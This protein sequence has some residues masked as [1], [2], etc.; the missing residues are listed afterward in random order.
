MR[1]TMKLAYL[2]MTCLALAGLSSVPAEAQMVTGVRLTVG[3]LAY[4][5]TSINATVAV[6]ARIPNQYLGPKT[7]TASIYE[8]DALW[9]GD[10]LV[11]TGTFVLT[12]A[13]NANRIE[14][15]TSTI[16]LNCMAC[17]GGKCD[18]GNVGMIDDEHGVHEVYASVGGVDSKIWKVACAKTTGGVF[19]VASGITPPGGSS[20]V[21]VSLRQE[22]PVAGISYALQYDPTWLSVTEASFDPAVVAAFQLTNVDYSV[23]GEVFFEAITEAP[24][25]VMLEEAFDLN[26]TFAVDALAPEGEYP[27]SSSVSSTVLD[28]ELQ[29]VQVNLGDE[30]FVVGAE[31]TDAPVIDASLVHYD[32]AAGTVTGAAGAVTEALARGVTRSGTG[33]IARIDA[34]LLDTASGRNTAGEVLA[35]ANGGFFV[36]GLVQEGAEALAIVATDNIGNKSASVEA[37]AVPQNPWR[38]STGLAGRQ[39]NADSSQPSLTHDGSYVV[40]DSNATN[41]VRNDTNGHKDVFVVDRTTGWTVRASV[42]SDGEQANGPSFAPSIAGD[43][44]NVAFV[45][46]ATNLVDI[47]TN[48]VNDIFMRDLGTAQTRRITMGFAGDEPNGLSLSPVISDQCSA[49]AYASDA[50]NLVM[51][52][53]NG[54]RDIFVFDTA[55]GI[56]E[57]ISVAD[58]GIEADADSSD[59]AI[60]AD[61]RYVAFA[62]NASNLVPGDTNFAPDIFVH[63]R[64]TGET[65]RVSVDSQGGEGFGFFQA[66]PAISADGRYVAFESDSPELAGQPFLDLASIF[67]H[68]RAT[69]ETTW[70]TPNGD[71]DHLN[72]EI[73]ADGM[74]IVFSSDSSNLVTG[75][76]GFY[77]D[78]FL[79]DRTTGETTLLSKAAGGATGNDDSGGYSNGVTISA[80][81]STV[82][83]ET[84]ANNLVDA[85]ENGRQDIVAWD[86][87][88]GAMT[89]ASVSTLGADG[90]D[91]AGNVSLAPAGRYIAYS[92][93]ASNLVPSDTNDSAD[94]FVYDSFTNRTER[95]SVAT[96]GI[97]ADG[98]SQTPSISADG[99]FVAFD[100]FSDALVSDDNNALS[101]IF[102]HDRQTGDTVRVSVA[103]D[104]TQADNMSF[105]PSVSE[106]GRWVAFVSYA[107]N[108][109][110]DDIN[111]LRDAFIKDTQTGLVE[112]ISVADVTGAEA[113]DESGEFL[114]T[115]DARVVSNDGRYVAFE[116]FAT[117]LNAADQNQYK[118]VYVRDRQD[119]RTRLISAN[120][121]GAAGNG[122]SD[123]PSMTTDGRFVVF[124]SEASD[125][126]GSDGNGYRDVFL[127]DTSSGIT[128]RVSIATDGSEGNGNSGERG[129]VAISEDGRYAV[130]TSEASNLVDGDFNGTADVFVRD[131]QLNTTF[132]LTDL[133]ADQPDAAVLGVSLSRMGA[134]GFVTAAGNLVSDDSNGL[135]DVYVVTY[136]DTDDDGVVDTMDNCRTVA[137]ADQRDVDADGIGDTCDVDISNDCL[138]NFGD[139]A[140]LKNLFLSADPLGDLN[141]DGQVN[142]GDLARLKSEFLTPA[143]ES[144]IA[145]ICAD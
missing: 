104:G 127:R 52:D 35:D 94:V 84:L 141:G 33:D 109:V 136:G 99:R 118:D 28:G 9:L 58:G 76:G 79:H 63:D 20:E 5:G 115:G 23:P 1:T 69:G 47:D 24:G 123:S 19:Q 73:S 62:S 130:F 119:G 12:G 11:G 22:T 82:V 21:Q 38:I 113:D 89:L 72:A 34:V 30:I 103:A 45:S 138:V 56:T 61:G 129:G 124:I 139:V 120:T 68:D 71:G 88:T 110:A 133:V 8:H 49:I 25:G 106:D 60:S 81:G 111:L 50:T 91:Q 92:S 37:L 16:P 100:S 142:F 85:D 18:F 67:L 7:F 77:R 29:E 97:E 114:F 54:A 143:G 27:M 44:L 102:M 43:G 107:A 93:A 134:V 55:T 75:D 46:A 117:N 105:N 40:F 48:A 36:D 137:N 4:C 6:D 122:D 108:L 95:V 59:P 140:I 121:V 10:D 31:D 32:R 135:R 64:Q 128:E 13:T 132:R 83:F 42:A 15:A 74:R 144:G 41:L 3:P 126:V 86:V 90:D 112:R 131:R 87:R 65:T 96:G 26:I 98:N 145:N 39:A 2:L 66:A 51:N 57:R 116:S 101:D 70:L 78:A 80:D 125:L 14:T 17:V 53:T